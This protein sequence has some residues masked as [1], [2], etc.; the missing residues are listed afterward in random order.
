MFSESGLQTPSIGLWNLASVPSMNNML[1]N[2]KLSV[3]SYSKILVDLSNNPT[4]PFP[5]GITLGA[6][7]LRYN[8]DGADARNT[9]QVDHGWIFEGDYEYPSGVVLLFNNLTVGVS[10]VQL[11]ISQILGPVT[12]VTSDGASYT[13]S[14][15]SPL[16]LATSTSMTLTVKGE[17]AQLGN[18]EITWLG[19]EFLTDVVSWF[20]ITHFIGA[21]NRCYNLRAVP[22]ALPIGTLDTSFMFYMSGQT[23]PVVFTGSRMIEAW[24]TILVTSMQSMFSGCDQLSPGLDFSAWNTGSVVNFSGMFD[25]CTSLQGVGIGQWDTH[26]ATD[27]SFMLANCTGLPASLSLAQWNTGLV[28]NFDFMFLGCPV[29]GVGV[30]FW[31]THSATSMSSMFNFCGALAVDF[32]PAKP[33]YPQSWNTGRLTD[34]SFMFYNALSANNFAGITKWN[35]ASVTSMDGVFESSTADLNLAAWDVGNVRSMR[36]MFNLSNTTEGNYSATLQ[37]WSSQ[38]VRRGVNVG[39]VGMFY[40]AAVGAEGRSTLVKAGWTFYGDLAKGSI[41]TFAVLVQWLPPSSTN[42][43]SIKYYTVKAK[44]TALV[45]SP[46]P[47][48]LF[49][50]PPPTLQTFNI[51]YNTDGTENYIIILNLLYN[52]SYTFYVD[53]FTT[54]GAS[55][56]SLPSNTIL[57]THL[58]PYYTPK[59]YATYPNITPGQNFSNYIQAGIRAPVINM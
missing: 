42:G 13:F 30:G 54:N 28:E 25:S 44:Y 33:G 1:D 39:A 35:T 49:N 23:T 7:N 27:M 58:T 59:R 32:T 31:D 11:P 51:F 3:V 41:A 9:L 46:N 53:A 34:M 48:R 2:S 17:F 47:Q 36:R 21:F 22:R 56:Y 12:I 5:R 37:G 26:S 55:V 19:S 38:R 8:S 6:L 20:G 50:P 40:N 29:T 24:N 57:V 16:I 4:N 18:A 52:T 14:Y 15:S 10:V 43:T 45:P